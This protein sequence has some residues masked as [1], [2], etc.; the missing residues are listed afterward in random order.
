MKAANVPAF[1]QTE[2]TVYVEAVA[3]R[4]LILD[5]DSFCYK[6]AN[7][8]KKLETAQR[9]FS[10]MVYEAMY[11]TRA[12]SVRVH[13]TP[14]DC[15]K[16]GRHLLRGVKLYQGNRQNKP[17]PPL[18]KPLR[19]SIANL[20]Y[21]LGKECTV[22]GHLQHEA[23]DGVMM[24]AY[25]Y[26]SNAV[27]QSEDKDLNIV[28]CAKYDPDTGR[29]ATIPDRF[30]WVAMGET[31]SGKPKPKGHGT[32]FFWLQC[33][34]GDTADNV[35]GIKTFNGKLCGPAAAMKAIVT[36]QDESRC[37]NIVLDAYRSI[38]QNILPE[39]EALWLLRW[40]GD[41]A[42]QY[43]LSLALTDANR[44]YLYWCAQ[45]PLYYT[46]EEYDK[47]VNVEWT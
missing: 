34:M 30:G 36:T 31:A 3:N 6:A 26:S 7:D 47:L 42:Y 28:P 45:Q 24:D 18:L 37:A 19:E 44:D 14:A 39:A 12:E 15:W 20:E 40:V 22:L 2:S 29:I 17:K 1:G 4:V 41:S 8:C 10:T 38:K 43:I 5:A 33:L 35:K 23:D 16:N 13:L 11:L 46:Q 25:T 27:V 32:K 9:R 21:T